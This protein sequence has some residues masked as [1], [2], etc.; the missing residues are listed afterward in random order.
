MEKVVVAKAILFDKQGRVLLIRRSQT[1]PRRPLEW[2]FPGGFVDDDDESYQYACL[3][4]IT[5]ETGLKI[6]DNHLKLAYT[7]SASGKFGDKEKDVSWLYFEGRVQTADVYLSFEHDDSTWAGL[8]EALRLITYDTQLR[9]LRY[10]KSVLASSERYAT[11][12]G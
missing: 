8:D 1:A 6:R 12:K 7:E 2:D 3:R 10:V 4:E 9:A 5:E 11:R